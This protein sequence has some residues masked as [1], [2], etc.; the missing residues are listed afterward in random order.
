MSQTIF[1]LGSNTSQVAELRDILKDRVADPIVTAAVGDAI[2]NIQHNDAVIVTGE[3]QRTGA[4]YRHLLDRLAQQAQ[5]AEV[6]G[7]LMR[8]FSSSLSLEDILDTVVAKSTKVLGDTAFILLNADAKLR[9]EAAFSTDPQRL[10]R[11][12]VTTVNVTPQ[13]VAGELLRDVLE[14]GKPLLVPNLNATQGLPELRPLIEKYGFMS[15]IAIPIRAKDRIFGAFISMSSGSRVLSDAELAPAEEL[16]DFTA[17]VVEN[18]RLFSE[19][20]RTATIDPL[21]GLFNTRLFH[22]VLSR[23]TARTHRYSTPLSLLM[24]DVDS[25]KRVNDNF[26]HPVGDKVLVHISQILERTV[27]NTDFVFRYGGDEFSVILPGTNVEGA[28][29]TAEKILQKVQSSQV[30]QIMGYPGLVSVSIGVSEY[31]KGTPSE[32]LISEADQALYASKRSTKNT[33]RV[34]PA[35]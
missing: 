10:T 5:R 18:A 26:G 2:P 7:E 17:M 27:R 15:L 12:L 30:P 28:V 16:A 19:L 22:E 33:Y 34:F 11:M 20:Q 29:R 32:T 4:L 13:T 6:L 25:F 23:E 21:T 1:I 14:G 24:I 35:D 31:R 8:L 9:L 3:E